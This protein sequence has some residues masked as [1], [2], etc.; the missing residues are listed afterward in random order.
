MLPIVSPNPLSSIYGG[1]VAVENAGLAVAE[2]A[3]L[4]NLP[5]RVCENGKPVPIQNADWQMWVEEMRDAGM[6]AYEA[7][8]RKDQD[9]IL[10]A[11]GALVTSCADCHGRYL[12]GSGGVTG[13]CE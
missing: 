5:G 6:I 3:N 4:L 10:D 1:W 12:S 11:A 2:S 13:P 9:A 7:A 8:K